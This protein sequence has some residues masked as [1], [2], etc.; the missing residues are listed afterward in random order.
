[1]RARVASPLGRRRSELVR[2]AAR[3]GFAPP[4]R[5]PSVRWAGR[6]HDVAENLWLLALALAFGTQVHEHHELRRWRGDVWISRSELLR[7][8]GAR[9]AAQD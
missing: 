2:L 1:M 9:A 5:E 4:R 7:R 8:F 3:F 6:A